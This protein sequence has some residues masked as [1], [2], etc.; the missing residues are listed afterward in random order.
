MSLRH[1]LLG[2]LAIQPST[3]YE[4]TRSFERSLGS[5]WHAGHSQ[6][7]PELIKLEEAGLVEVVG[8][9]ARRSR[10]YGLT[11]SGR[12]E[13]RLWLVVAE[14]SRSQRNETLLRWF[15]LA[16]LTPA[17]RRAAL[18]RELR[19]VEQE[20]STLERLWDHHVASGQDHPFGPTLDFGRRYHDL[21]LDWLREQLT[22]AQDVGT[23]GTEDTEPRSTA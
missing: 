13:L 21:A 15:L 10:T 9:G 20:R 14:P 7:Y 6:I 2:L 16:Q 18:E 1:A 3:G 23:T 22:A 8:E 4:L 11:S 12:E 19:F 5:A 17:D